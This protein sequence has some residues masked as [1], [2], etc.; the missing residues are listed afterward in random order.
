MA[1]HSKM[2]EEKNTVLED[3]SKSQI[4]QIKAVEEQLQTAKELVESQQT[5]NSEL[6]KIT[7]ILKTKAVNMSKRLK[8]SI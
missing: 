6:Y 8:E 3:I 2:L 1:L 5:Q 4:N 7:E